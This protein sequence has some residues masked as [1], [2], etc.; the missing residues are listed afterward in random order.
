MTSKNR[1]P[2]MDDPKRVLHTYFKKEGRRYSY[3]TRMVNTPFESPDY[4][5]IEFS[6]RGHTIFT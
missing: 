2:F 5:P 3:P 4:G 6:L 1:I